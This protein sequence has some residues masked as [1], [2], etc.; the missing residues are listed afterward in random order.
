MESEEPHPFEA[1]YGGESEAEEE[2]VIH[3]EDELAARD[4]DE[5]P[6]ENPAAVKKAKK[7]DAKSKY[8]VFTINNPPAQLVPEGWAHHKFTVWQE[9]KVKKRGKKKWKSR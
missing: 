8:W 4:A 5:L 1:L 7:N 9:E 6:E 3:D 2:V